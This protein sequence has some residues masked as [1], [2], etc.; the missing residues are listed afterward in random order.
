VLLN[1]RVVFCLK[2]LDLSHNIIALVSASISTTIVLLLTTFLTIPPHAKLGNF[3]Q[4]VLSDNHFYCS[5]TLL[6]SQNTC[7][8]SLSRGCLY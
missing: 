5:T 3:R 8:I 2:Y 7:L 6:T 1:T 4:F